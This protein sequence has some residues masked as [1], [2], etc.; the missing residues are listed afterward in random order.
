MLRLRNASSGG[1]NTYQ[2]GPF[3]GMHKAF[4]PY[5]APEG[6]HELTFTSDAEAIETSVSITDSFGLVRLVAGMG[7]LPMKFN[8]SAPSKFCTPEDIGVE[9]LPY[10]LRKE[11]AEKILANSHQFTPRLTL[12]RQGIPVPYD[13]GYSVM[14]PDE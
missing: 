4:G 10:E 3:W 6:E 2:I 11:R 12:E 9:T 5:C 1:T 7:D 8:T 13:Q 14:D